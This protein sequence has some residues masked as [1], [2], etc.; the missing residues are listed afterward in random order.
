MRSVCYPHGV[1]STVIK[2]HCVYKNGMY[3]EQ[4]QAITFQVRSNEPAI[5]HVLAIAVLTV[6]IEASF[7]SVTHRNPLLRACF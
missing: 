7:F 6:T 2:R 4:K 5:G 1:F 3:K